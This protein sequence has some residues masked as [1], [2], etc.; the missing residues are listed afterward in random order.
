VVDESHEALL[1]HLNV[2][3]PHTSVIST[4]ATNVVVEE[5]AKKQ[6]SDIYT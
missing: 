4:A 2:K 1:R 5:E 6:I 3:L